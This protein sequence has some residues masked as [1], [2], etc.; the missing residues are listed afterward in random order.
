MHHWL[1]RHVY[2]PA[3]RRGVN[4]HAAT[5]LVFFISAVLHEVLASVPCRTFRLWAFWGMMTQVPLV[6]FTR[7]LDKRLSKN[8]HQTQLGNVIFWVSFCFV[9]QPLCLLL[10]YYDYSL[11]HA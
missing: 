8:G 7:A 11:K 9:G 5:L 2:F 10:Y 3:L 6:V 1:L 4:K